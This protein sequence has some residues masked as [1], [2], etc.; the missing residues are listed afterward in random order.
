[1]MWTYI[2][3]KKRSMDDSSHSCHLT[4]QNQRKGYD[5]GAVRLLFLLF[6]SHSPRLRIAE[7]EPFSPVRAGRGYLNQNTAE[8]GRKWQKILSFWDTKSHTVT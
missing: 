8:G 3:P 5:S 2:H 7:L 1:M 4:R 6:A